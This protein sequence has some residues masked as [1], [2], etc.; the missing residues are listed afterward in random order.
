MRSFSIGGRFIK[1]SKSRITMKVT[2]MKRELSYPGRTTKLR[3]VG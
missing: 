2:K 3:K 1:G